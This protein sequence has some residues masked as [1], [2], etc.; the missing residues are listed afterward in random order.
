MKPTR[1][2]LLVLLPAAL[3]A[4]G[5]VGKMPQN[6]D[7]FRQALTEGAFLTKID[8]YE[9]D[10]S[11]AE[12]GKTFKKYAPK[13][14]DKRIETISQT[15]TSYQHIITKYTPTVVAGRDRVELHLQEKHE[16]GVLAVYEEPEA[17]H[18]MLVVDVTP[19]GKNRSKVEFYRPSM[20]FKNMMT[21]IENW[22]RGEN[23]GC[24]DLTK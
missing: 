5:C 23:L 3:L 10:R 15:R 4:G 24:P 18:Y 22:T 20:G 14:L 16:Q 13:C 12:I 17:G 11:T 7:E 19:V 9:V 2:A 21:A 1:F 6:P 8:T